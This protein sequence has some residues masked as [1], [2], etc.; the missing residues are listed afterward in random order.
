MS[1]K[2]YKIISNVMDISISELTDKSGP[3]NIENWDSYN[4]LLLIDELE[5]E[6]NV[7][8]SVDETYDVKIIEDIKR[9]LKNH[10]V[11]LDD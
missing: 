7:K 10:G 8:F 6:F 4:G 3:E 5:S 1:Q 9:H 11:S 2:L